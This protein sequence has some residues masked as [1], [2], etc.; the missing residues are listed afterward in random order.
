MYIRMI[1]LFLM[2]PFNGLPET[3]SEIKISEKPKNYL[4]KK[5]SLDHYPIAEV[6]AAIAYHECY[7]LAPLERWLVM[8]AFYNRVVY[9]YNNNG[10]SVKEQLLAPKQFTGLFKYYT[11]RFKFDSNDELINSNYNMALEILSGARA[12]TDRIIFYWAGK[13]DRKTSHGKFVKKEEIGYK[14][15]N[16]F[17]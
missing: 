12:S 5:D 11:S 14:T 16:W 9:N 6:M 8:E 15:L 1:L 3:K 13:C 7:N 17:R 2:L 10:R 4:L